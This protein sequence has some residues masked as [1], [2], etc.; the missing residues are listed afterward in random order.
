MT[1]TVQLP[2][3]LKVQCALLNSQSGEKGLRFQLLLKIL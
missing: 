3:Q 2:T 1:F